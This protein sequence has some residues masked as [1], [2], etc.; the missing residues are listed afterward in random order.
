M[1]SGDVSEESSEKDPEKLEAQR[2]FDHIVV[3]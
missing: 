1:E 3:Q 2:E